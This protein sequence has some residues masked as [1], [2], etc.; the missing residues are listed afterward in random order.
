MRKPILRI[1]DTNLIFRN[2]SGKTSEYNK[3]GE[4][5]TGVIIPTEMVDQLVEEGWNV[6]HTNP[7]DPQAE[8]LYYMNVKCRFDNIPPKVYLCTERKKTLLDEETINQID[9]SEISSV[10]IEIS[11]YDYTTALG[12]GRTA[13][14]K[15]MYVNVVEDYFAEKYDYG[16]VED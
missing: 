5:I 10:D 7:R 11:P 3:N 4:R 8:P 2:L 15:N 12:S 13:Y 14:V 9:Y 6:K 1:A 16:D